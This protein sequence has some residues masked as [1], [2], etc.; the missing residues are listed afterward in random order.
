VFRSDGTLVASFVQDGM[1]RPLDA[2]RTA[3]VL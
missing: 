2:G 3:P 1:I